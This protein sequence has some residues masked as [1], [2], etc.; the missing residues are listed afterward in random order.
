ARLGAALDEPPLSSAHRTR[1]AECLEQAG[2]DAA[3]STYRSALDSDPDNYRAARGFARLAEKSGDRGLLR[4]AAEYELDVSLDLDRGAELLVQAAKL[5]R[6]RG[7]LD[8]AARD[9]T[10][11]R[12]VNP[13][14]EATA[15]ALV[16]TLL[17]QGKVDALY[18]TLLNA[19]NSTRLQARHA[20]LWNLIA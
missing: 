17:L 2:D 16:E 12:E 5:E 13:D 14:H 20:A 7:D 8:A 9:L 10:T 18:D 6:E 3:L 15:T 4:E 1:L 19:A 11:A